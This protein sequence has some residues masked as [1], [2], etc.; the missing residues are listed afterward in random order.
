MRC[1]LTSVRGRPTRSSRAG[2]ADGPALDQQR[3]HAPRRRRRRNRSARRAARPASGS[4]ARNTDDRAAQADPGD[5]QLLAQ[6]EAERREAEEHR[7]RPR[8]Q[9]QHQRHRERRQ[10]PLR[11]PLRPGQQ[12]EQHEHRDL[13][14]PGRGVEERHDG[15]VRAGLAVADH[16]AGDIDREKARAVQR[17]RPGRTS[18]A[19]R[20]RR[21]A[22]ACPAAAPGG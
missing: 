7:G 22:R 13:R 20:S 6:A 16:E 1:A 4:T 21:T 8:D 12:A 15:V 18:P 5:E 10:Q 3:Q 19:R 2:D 11:Q 14:E 17:I 9:H